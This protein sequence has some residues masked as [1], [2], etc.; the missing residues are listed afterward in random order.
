MKSVK[1]SIESAEAASR[2]ELVVRFIYGTVVSIILGLLGIFAFVAWGVQFLHILFTAK[3]HKSL[4]K[5]I[6]AYQI[7]YTQLEFYVMLS[8]DERPPMFPA[9]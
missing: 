2:K 1:V 8:T 4:S 3:R 9:F 5:F 6:N 7:A